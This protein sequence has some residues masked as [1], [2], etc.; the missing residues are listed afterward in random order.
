MTQ[1]KPLFWRIR[2][3]KYMPAGWTGS[4]VLIAC[5][6][7]MISGLTFAALN[8]LDGQWLPVPLGIALAGA[9]LLTLIWACANRAQKHPKSRWR[10]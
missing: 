7:A 10:D 4:L 8:A 5:L 1:A 3:T 6:S 9:G 2:G